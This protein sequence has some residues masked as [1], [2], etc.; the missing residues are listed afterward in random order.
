MRNA[1]LRAGGAF[2]LLCLTGNAA[3][4][5]F[6]EGSAIIAYPEKILSADAIDR[7]NAVDPDASITEYH[8]DAQFLVTHRLAGPDLGKTAR[9][10]FVGNDEHHDSQLFMIVHRDGI[11][12]LWARRA[13]QPVGKELCLSARQVAELDLIAAFATAEDDG[14]GQRCIK[15]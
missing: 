14:K 13:W 15:I 9:I 2:L 6:G 4:Q 10:S 3:N 8:Y 12:R 1:V 11:G 7:S 5:P